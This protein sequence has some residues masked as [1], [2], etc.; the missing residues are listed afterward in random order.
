MADLRV[1][2]F[3]AYEMNGQRSAIAVL[4][5]AFVVREPAWFQSGRVELG[6]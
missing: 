6:H 1:T 2:I 3:L 5:V 4:P